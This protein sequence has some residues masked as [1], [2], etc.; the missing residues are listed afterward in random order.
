MSRIA[1]T[2]EL[3]VRGMNCPLPVLKTK[4]AIVNLATG[5]ILKVTATDPGSLA[6]M[7][8]FSRHTGHEIIEHSRDDGEFVFFLRK[9]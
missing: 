1:P 8:A 9:A 6:D 2:V 4:K 7:Q 5:D 3:D